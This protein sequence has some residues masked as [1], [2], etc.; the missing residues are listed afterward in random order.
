MGSGE[1]MRYTVIIEHYGNNYGAYVPDLPGCGAT[2][3]TEAE[4]TRNIQTA[5]EN[6][7]KSMREDGDPIPQP[8]SK[9]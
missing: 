9:V 8:T 3:A 2:G 5:I 7:L 6:H 4:V 1:A